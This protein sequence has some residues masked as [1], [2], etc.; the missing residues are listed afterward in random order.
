M[1]HACG[2]HSSVLRTVR[3]LKSAPSVCLYGEA[4]TIYYCMC[5]IIRTFCVHAD[6][7]TLQ[8][9]WKENTELCKRCLL[10]VSHCHHLNKNSKRITL[11]D[12]RGEGGKNGLNK[13]PLPFIKRRLRKLVLS[14]SGNGKKKRYNGARM[15]SNTADYTHCGQ[16]CISEQ[17]MCFHSGLSHLLLEFDSIR[18]NEDS[19]DSGNNNLALCD[20]LRRLV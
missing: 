18:L 6:N 2:L 3:V 17:G 20:G 4:R 5:N 15:T 1:V 19:Q 12:G 9:G 16:F 7:L 13:D 10:A 8:P 14:E 11:W